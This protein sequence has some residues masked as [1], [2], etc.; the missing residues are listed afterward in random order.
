M[1]E[2]LPDVE[3]MPKY[4]SRHGYWSSAIKALIQ[5]GCF[6]WTAKASGDPSAFFRRAGASHSRHAPGAVW[7]IT[8]LDGKPLGHFVVGDRAAVAVIPAAKE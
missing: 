3:L 6:V 7:L 2:I 4:F 1:R 5:S 8:D